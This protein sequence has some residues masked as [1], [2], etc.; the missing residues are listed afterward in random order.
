MAKKT[1]IG[2]RTEFHYNPDMSGDIE[3]HVAS[4][5]KVNVPTIDL[6]TFIANNIVEDDSSIM[7]HIVESPSTQI[8]RLNM[9]FEIKKKI[10]KRWG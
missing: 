10:D 4:E 1:F 3:I 6:I 5:G 2:G 8:T 7:K 9:S